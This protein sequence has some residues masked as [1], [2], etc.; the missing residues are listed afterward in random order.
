[1]DAM[2]RCI[3]ASQLILELGEL[4]VQV[5]NGRGDLGVVGSRRRYVKS[6]QLE[7]VCIV[8]NSYVGE[9]ILYPRIDW[10]DSES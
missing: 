6:G 10:V 7:P 5:M 8:Q 4:N 1:M 9:S 3:D 2:R